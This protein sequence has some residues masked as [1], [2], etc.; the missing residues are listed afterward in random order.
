MLSLN[1]K[2]NNVVNIE[3]NSIHYTRDT[4]QHYLPLAHI[5]FKHL[6][7]RHA[8]IV[9]Q[10]GG[11]ILEIGFGLNCSADKFISSNISS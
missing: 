3:S 11:H 9:S 6:E 2:K 1:F 4:N 10:N 7:E 5:G 8:E